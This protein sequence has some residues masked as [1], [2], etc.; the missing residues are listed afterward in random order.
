LPLVLLVYSSSKIVQVLPLWL[1][2]AELI[3]DSG[4]ENYANLNSET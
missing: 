3:L 4:I 1:L 2:K